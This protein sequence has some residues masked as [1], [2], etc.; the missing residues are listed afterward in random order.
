M[1]PY[2]LTSAGGVNSFT[3]QPLYPPGESRLYLLG[4]PRASLNALDNKSILLF[5]YFIL[6]SCFYS[7]NLKM[8]AVCY[9]E[10]PTVVIRRMTWCYIP[11]RQRHDIWTDAAMSQKNSAVLVRKRTIPTGRPPL[12]GVV[13]TLADRGCLCHRN[14]MK[15]DFWRRPSRRSQ[16]S[17]HCRRRYSKCLVNKDLRGSAASSLDHWLQHGANPGPST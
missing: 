4:E 7:S 5:P 10:T 11:R 1:G 14:E 8:E 16:Q 17:S 3:L 13:S 6:F 2:I 9:S 12:V 15:F